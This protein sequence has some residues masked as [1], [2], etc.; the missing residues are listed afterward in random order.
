MVY[1]HTKNPTYGKF[2][3]ALEWNIL[4]YFMAIW[5]ILLL[6]GIFLGNL[7]YFN[8]VWYILWPVGIF[9]GHFGIFYV[10]LVYNSA[11]WCIF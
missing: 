11:V 9:Y 6:Y 5:Y 8:V 3:K 4:V 2:M 10:N 1:L 7:V